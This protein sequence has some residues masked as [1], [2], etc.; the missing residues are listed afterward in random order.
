[1]RDFRQHESGGARVRFAGES[2]VVQLFEF[3]IPRLQRR[4]ALFG[5]SRVLCADRP[6]RWAIYVLAAYTVS[7]W[8]TIVVAV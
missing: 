6:A 5:T 3:V 7:R 1:M 2:V 8:R 4:S